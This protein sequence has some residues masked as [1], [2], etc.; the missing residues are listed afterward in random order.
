MLEKEIEK[1]KETR[2][3][4]EASQEISKSVFNSSIDTIIS[5][6]LNNNIT[7]ISPSACYTFGYEMEE[8]LGK[9]S[10]ELYADIREFNEIES[11]LKTEGFYIGEILNKRK[12][13]SVFTSF[14][15]CAALNNNKGNKIGFMGISRDITDLKKAEEELIESEKKY[16]DLFI[17][18]SDA[19]IVVDKDNYIKELNNAATKLLEIDDLQRYNLIDFVH[20]DDKNYV[21]KILFLVNK[22]EK[23][24]GASLM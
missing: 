6:D 16:R 11:H 3:K 23:I 5:T 13:G 19:V 2:R 7:E 9:K 18:L 8:L 17:N 12:D 10:V 22:M 15:S 21:L 4:L 1:H 24:K 20:Q 14:L